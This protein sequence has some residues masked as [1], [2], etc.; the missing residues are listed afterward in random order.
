MPTYDFTSP[1]GQAYSI[2]GPEGSTREQAFQLLPQKYPELKGKPGFGD[3]AAKPAAPTATATATAPQKPADAAQAPQTLGDSAATVGASAALGGVAGALAP[4]IVSGLGALSLAIP[5]VG[6]VAAPLLFAA[7]RA[8]RAGRVAEAAA[9]A[10]S[11]AVGG[12]ASEATRAAGGSESAQAL[13]GFAGGMAAPGAAAVAGFLPKAAQVTWK[14]ARKFTEGAEVS[15]EAAVKASR[16]KL[17]DAA[18]TNKPLLDMHAMLQK[19]AEADIQAS[20]KAAAD[21]LSKAHTRASLLAQSNPAAAEQAIAAAKAQGDQL[22]RDAAA[23]MEVLDKA[24]GGKAKLAERV[25]KMAEPELAKVGGYREISDIGNDLRTKVTG[26]QRQAIEQRMQTDKAL[27]AHRDAVVAG[28]EKAGQFVEQMPAMKEL[29]NEISR[30]MLITSKGRAAAGGMAEVTES[31]VQGAYQKVWDSITNRRVQTGMTPDGAPTYET[32]KTSFEALDHVRRKLGDA[33]FGGDKEGYGALGQTIAKDLYGKISKIQTEFAGESQ[34]ALQA[35]YKGATEDMTKFGTAAGKKLTAVDRIDPEV[36]AKDPAG[37]PTAYFRSQ[38]GVKDLVELT[39]DTQ[40]VYRAAED[41]A[42]RQIAGKDAAQVQSWLKSP[43][44]TDWMR[45]VPGLQGKEQAYGEKLARIEATAGKLE[46]KSAALQAERQG[47]AK[48]LPGQ[49]D[50]VKA[51]GLAEATA[52]VG[53]R[54]EEGKEVVRSASEAGQQMTKTAVEQAKRI[55]GDDFPAT[56]VRKLL[57]QG[58]PEDLKKAF[59][60]MAG[61]PGGREAIEGSVR[62]TLSQ[63]SLSPGKLKSLWD[64][65]LSVAL[66][67]SGMEPA[68]LA[69]LDKEVKAVIAREEPKAARTKVQKL[70]NAAIASTVNNTGAPD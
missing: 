57:T 66:Q 5:G 24:S 22:R 47:I 44:Q 38:Q 37:I 39:G 42:T 59:Q 25:Q 16:A 31:G 60:Y 68:R 43:M 46:A 12:V 1:D 4:E 9:G 45:E 67:S 53:S 35:A 14:A 17:L 33:A 70:L 8:M 34:T 15:T 63:A 69:K 26:V 55:V 61:A 64:D 21:L 49:L 58:K 10:L 56:E 20:E 19:G 2:E 13:A 50:K 36:F 7:G 27:R 32:F 3:A 40:S 29:K 11:G 54:V 65:R 6:E 62:N 30:K 18:T 48:A 52:R 28:K 23:R 51:E 41:Y